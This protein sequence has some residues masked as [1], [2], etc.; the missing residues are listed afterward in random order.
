MSVNEASVPCE[1][2]DLALAESGKRQIEWAFQSMPVLAS[3]RKQFIKTQAF[4]GILVSASLPVTPEAANLVITLRD[5]G[6]KIALCG[7]GALV[8]DDVA[9]SLVKDYAVPVTR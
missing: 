4:I 1:I 3:I 9:A 6:A 8:H 5:G 2:K 7:S